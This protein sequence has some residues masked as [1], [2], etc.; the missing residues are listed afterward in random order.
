MQEYHSLLQFLMQSPLINEQKALIMVKSFTSASIEKN[1]ILLRPGQ[2]SD[3]Y[4]FIEDG[5]FRSYALDTDGNEITTGFF[6]RHQVVFEVN[7][8]FNRVPSQEYIQALVHTRAFYI[9]FE[10]LNQ[11]FH[12]MP[13]FREF[14]RSLLV[15]GYS[16]LKQRM[17]SI[18]TQ[19]AEERYE[20][21]LKQNPEIFEKAPLK[22][23][24]TYLGITDTSLSRIRKE[25]TKK[26]S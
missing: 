21:L 22:A 2:I 24:A 10:S 7:S 25:L 14:G 3:Q 13:E 12:T 23:I 1:Q 5:F 6:G 15:K 17:L 9:S 20:L 19:T 8:F 18:I 11:L 4:F 16:G 26:H